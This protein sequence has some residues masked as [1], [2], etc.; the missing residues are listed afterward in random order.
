MLLEELLWGHQWP[1]HCKSNSQ[2]TVYFLKLSSFYSLFLETFFSLVARTSLPCGSL[3]VSAIT[4]SWCPSLAA[5]CAPELNSWDA[6]LLYLFSLPRWWSHSTLHFKC[7]LYSWELSFCSSNLDLSLK[8]RLLPTTDFTTSPLGCLNDILDQTSPKLNSWPPHLKLLSHIF[9]HFGKG[10]S[11][12]PGI[13]TWTHLWLLL[14]PHTTH[15]PILWVLPSKCVLDLTVF[16]YVPCI[17]PGW[18]HYY[19]Y[20]NSNNSL[21]TD[22]SA[23]PC[24]ISFCSPPSSQSDPVKMYS[25]HLLPRPNTCAWFAPSIPQIP[26]QMSSKQRALP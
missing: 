11:P 17:H 18:N 16:Y 5:P 21:L 1:P 12:H 22:L 15:Q 7:H 23:S 6:S 3:P 20:L 19:L 10:N 26:V 13:Q 25:Y 9:A 8:S 14:L 2:F 24:S 4:H